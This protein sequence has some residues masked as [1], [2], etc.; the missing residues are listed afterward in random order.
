VIF[1]EGNDFVHRFFRRMTTSLGLLDLLRVSA[2]LDDEIED[3]KHVGNWCTLSKSGGVGAWVVMSRG[4]IESGIFHSLLLS[5]V[6]G[7]A[8]GWR[9]KISHAGLI[10]AASRAMSDSSCH[11][12]YIDNSKTRDSIAVSQSL[13]YI[14]N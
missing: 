12:L 7:L 1:V 8:R 11:G 10:Q 14:Q 5:L 13:L 6:V 3:V 9:A 2:L 4:L